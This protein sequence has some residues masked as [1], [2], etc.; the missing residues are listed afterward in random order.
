MKKLFFVL[1]A[2]VI[3]IGLVSAQLNPT[4]PI[5]APAEHEFSAVIPDMALITP[6][7]MAAVFKVHDQGPDYQAGILSSGEFMT[8]VN[9]R[10]GVLYIRELRIKG[11][12]LSLVPVGF[13]LLC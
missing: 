11:L 13:P 10:I 4:H 6:A 3:G 9:G 1:L 2:M 7:P 8:L 12:L 5:G